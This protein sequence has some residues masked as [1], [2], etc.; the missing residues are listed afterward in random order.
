MKLIKQTILSL[1]TMQVNLFN[2]LQVEVC[3]NASSLT[4]MSFKFHVWFRSE[5]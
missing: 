5:R 3:V 4:V 1:Q 2:G